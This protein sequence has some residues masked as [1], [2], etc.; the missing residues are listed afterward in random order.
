MNVVVLLDR[1]PDADECARTSVDGEWL[2]ALARLHDLVVS[3]DEDSAALTAVRDADVP[4]HVS[5]KRPVYVPG[6]ELMDADDALAG[7]LR[8]WTG[9]DG[10]DLVL[11]SPERSPV[12][13]LREAFPTTPWGVLA[14]AGPT[15]SSRRLSMDAEWV[16]RRGHELWRAAS[17]VATAD[18]VVSPI[19]PDVLGLR[20]ASGRVTSMLPPPPVDAVDR[21][22]G[23]L[24]VVV[25]IGAARADAS[26][27][28]EGLSRTTS[29]FPSSAVVVIH[30]PDVL[31]GQPVGPA[32]AAA[33][34]DRIADRVALVPA[35]RHGAAA[36]WLEAA[37]AL[38]L[39]DADELIVPAVA[40]RAAAVPTAVIAPT[41]VG[42]AVVRNIVSTP[43]RRPG[44]S[45][46]SLVRWTNPRRVRDELRTL[47]SVEEVELAVVHTD[48]AVVT[49]R[50]VTARP[51]VSRY[52]VVVATASRP[53]WHVPD[54]RA[55][56]GGVVGLH[57]RTWGPIEELLGA[58]VGLEALISHLTNIAGARSHTIGC[59]PARQP[60]TTVVTPASD[61]GPLELAHGPLPDL[62]LPTEGGGVPTGPAARPRTAARPTTR[63]AESTPAEPGPTVE[64]WARSTT[65][66]DRAMAA[67]PW[68]FGLADAVADGHFPPAVE[69]WIRTHGVADRIRLALP[70]RFALLPRAL[71]GRW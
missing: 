32:F 33:V 8:S 55:I 44:G 23:E 49:A 60:L 39:A 25:A 40:R 19:R 53:P 12:G 5:D 52:D 24:V 4:V 36:A 71:E 58:G 35:D 7:W 51:G 65:W 62:R 14:A 54:M 3:V 37:D 47:Q 9:P 70:W 64:S 17:H 46:P 29:L 22:S 13:T 56:E 68:R 15:A 34:P 41:R 63:S 6:G 2:L 18:L 61:G 66:K 59:V 21:V 20:P 26:L 1:V 28:M 42:Q 69:R 10:P 27:V 50:D 45:S 38:V 30:A 67:R 57:R 48:D 43:P 11:A 31:G 16:G